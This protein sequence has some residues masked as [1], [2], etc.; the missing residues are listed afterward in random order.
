MGGVHPAGLIARGLRNDSQT[1]SEVTPRLST[2]LRQD[3]DFTL[4][5]RR[6]ENEINGDITRKVE[7][8]LA[9]GQNWTGDEPV[10]IICSGRGDEKAFGG[11][12]HMIRGLIAQ[13]A[14]AYCSGAISYE[15]EKAE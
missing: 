14:S 12:V 7:V 13:P 8:Q 3:G 5:F 2:L 9:P 15:E 6:R 10:I 11:E 1:L 4:G